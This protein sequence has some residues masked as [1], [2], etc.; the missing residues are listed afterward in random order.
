MLVLQQQQKV[1]VGLDLG[2]RKQN[3]HFNVHMLSLSLPAGNSPYVEP[4][5]EIIVFL[6]RIIHAGQ[7]CLPW[8]CARGALASVRMLLLWGGSTARASQALGESY[9]KQSR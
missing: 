2:G 7:L 1:I 5:K 9:P 4:P 6:A 8:L 3:L